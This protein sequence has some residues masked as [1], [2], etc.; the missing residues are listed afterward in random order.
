MRGDKDIQR[1]ALQVSIALAAGM[2][3]IVPVAYG[4]P[5]GE[6]VVKGGAEVT[7]TVAAS[8]V[9][10]AVDTKISSSTTNN[11]IDWHDFS[12]D[13]SE[14]VIF[15]NG[16]KT[17][18][19][20]NVVTGA[21]TS[22]INGV[23][24]GGNEVYIINPNGV[25]FG[26][27]ASVDVG[28]L[29]AS[30]RY[31]SDTVKNAITEDGSTMTNVLE[32]ASAG[33][34]TDIVNMG[35]INATNVVMEGQNIRFVNDTN[36][37]N[38]AVEGKKGVTSTSVTLKADTT[39][40]GYI[41]VG[42]NSGSEPGYTGDNIEYFKLLGT[43]W[44]TITNTI[45][46]DATGNYMLSENVNAG[47]SSASIT[48]EFSGKFDGNNHEISNISGASSLFSAT[49]GAEIYNVGIVDSTFSGSNTGMVVGNAQASNGNNTV[50]KN[51]Y[52]NSSISG[53][54]VSG[55]V[56]YGN[57][58]DIVQCYNIG[59]LPLNNS[60]AFI[61][62]VRSGTNKIEDSYSTANAHY[63]VSALIL[64]GATLNGNRLYSKGRAFW[65][66]KNG[67]ASLTN[68][69][70]E[71][72]TT[73]GVSTGNYYIFP[74]NEVTNHTTASGV[75]TKY[76]ATYT[77]S[78]P[79]TEMNWGSNISDTG[80]VVINKDTGVV[81]RPVWRIYEGQTMPLLTSQ[82]KGIKNTVYNFAYFDADDNK[83]DTLIY[84]GGSNGAKDIPAYTKLVNNQP[85]GLVYN[86]K[87][88]KMLGSDG[89]AATDSSGAFQTKGISAIDVS[90]VSYDTA[91]RKNATFTK[92]SQ[93]AG[94]QNKWAMLYSSQQGYDLYGNNIEIAPRHVSASTSDIGSVT[95]V[96]EY[97][98]NSTASSE[99]IDDFFS[100]DNTTVAGILSEDSE[101]TKVTF[102]GTAKFMKNGSA[103]KDVGVYTYDADLEYQDE[104]WASM[105]YVDL[106][107]TINLT[108]PTNNYLLTDTS[109]TGKAQG[110]ITQKSLTIGL[111]HENYSRVYN[112]HAVAKGAVDGNV[113]IDGN[114]QANSVVDAS[115]FKLTVKDTGFTA[116]QEG[117][118]GTFTFKDDNN[119][120]KTETVTYTFNDTAYYVE[121][122]GTTIAYA[123]DDNG[124][125]I[126]DDNDNKIE[127][128]DVGSYTNRVRFD[129]LKLSG[130]TVGNYK[131]VDSSGNV[132]YSASPLITVT[133][134]G[135]NKY[136][137]TQG[138][139]VTAGGALYASGTV[140]QRPIS[141]TGFSWYKPDDNQVLQK[142][143]AT[144]PYNGYSAYEAPVGY[145][146]SNAGV[147]SGDRGMLEGDNLTF[148]VQSAEFV[149]SD[150]GTLNNQNQRVAE[151]T[152]NVADAQGVLYT[153]SITGDS[154]RNYTLDGAAINTSGTNTVIGKGSL[155]ARTINLIV[156]AD[157]N[158]D[159]TYDGKVYV[160]GATED[161]PA[162]LKHADLTAGTGYLKYQNTD[163]D[164]HFLGDIDPDA[165]IKVIGTYQAMPAAEN[166][167]AV[168]AKDV[169]YNE[170]S[171]EV[172]DKN[173]VY[174]A[175]VMD[176]DDDSQ[177]YQFAII[178]NGN[179]NMT[180]LNTENTQ[181][182][183]SGTDAKGKIGQLEID[184]VVFSDTMSKTFDNDT[185]VKNIVN[186]GNDVLFKTN[187]RITVT[188]LKL[189]GSSALT[190]TGDTIDDVLNTTNGQITEGSTGDT[191]LIVGVYGKGSGDNWEADEHAGDKTIRYTLRDGI[192]QNHNYKLTTDA[193]VEG[194]GTINKLPIAASA[195]KL[196]RNDKPITK[197]Y[198]G[199]AD[200]ATVADS[201]GNVARTADY[202]LT[203]RKAYVSQDNKILPIA[204]TV[205]GAEYETR[206]HQNDAGE[207][208]LSVSYTLSFAQSE[209]Y[210]IEGL[211]NNQLTR[212]V[213]ANGDDITGTI[214]PRP[215]TVTTANI[216]NND[217][218]AGG[219]VKVYNALNTVEGYGYGE[220]LVSGINAQV[221]TADS[222]VTNNTEGTYNNKHVNS[223]DTANLDDDGLKPVTY[224]LSLA[225]NTY[226]DYKFVDD[227]GTEITSVIGK[228]T[229]TPLNINT[230]TTTAYPIKTYTGTADAENKLTTDNMIF[231]NAANKVVVVDRDHID[232]TKITGMYQ[233]TGNEENAADVNRGGSEVLDKNVLYSGVLAAL[234]DNAG[235]YI[236][237]DTFTGTGKIK[238]ATIS[239]NDFYLVISDNIT[240]TY[241][242]SEQVGEYGMTN[243][244]R[245]LFQRYWIDTNNSGVDT[246]QDGTVDVKLANGAFEYIIEKAEFTSADAGTNNKHVDYQIYVKPASINNY[247]YDEHDTVKKDNIHLPGSSDTATITTRDVVASVTHEQLSKYYDGTEAI[248]LGDNAAYSDDN[249]TGTLVQGAEAVTFSAKVGTVVQ[250]ADGSV[251]SKVQTG[252]VNSADTNISYGSYDGADVGIGTKTI[253]Y[254][255]QIGG[256]N[257]NNYRLVDADGNVLTNGQ[258]LSTM[259]NTINPFGV[260]V[261]TKDTLNKTYDG[262]KSVAK[263]DAEA[264]LVIGATPANGVA[265]EFVAITDTT[266]EYDDPNVYRLKDNSLT[267]DVTYSGLQFTSGNYTMVDANGNLLDYN[268]DSQSYAVTGKGTISPLKLDRDRIDVVIDVANK[269]YDNSYV[270]KKDGVETT[271]DNSYIDH[272][273]VK[274]ADNEWIDLGYEYNA[275]YTNKTIAAD[276]VTYTLGL[277]GKTNYNIEYDDGLFNEDYANGYIYLNG[278][279]YEWRQ[280]AAGTID[281][282]TVKVALTGEPG[283]NT[284]I[285]TYDGNESVT[286]PTN[287]ADKVQ[288]TGLDFNDGTSYSVSNIHYD[289][290]D[291]ARDG[292]GNVI[293]KNVFYSVALTGDAK[294]N[295]KIEA[296]DGTT[297]DAD[298]AINGEL[299]GKG[300]ITAKTLSIDFGYAEKPYD[301]TDDVEPGDIAPQLGGFAGNES[302][303]LDADAISLI[304][305]NYTNA[306]VNRTDE[307]GTVGFKGLTYEN[308]QAALTDYAGR[309]G[310][311]LNYTIA[312]TKSYTVDDAKGKIIPKE[313]D[314]V[315]AVWE[316]GVTR[317]YDTTK[318]IPDEASVLTLQVATP[319]D[320]QQNVTYSYAKAEYADPNVGNHALR[321][322]VD[323]VTTNLVNYEL[324]SEAA[325]NAKRWWVSTDTDNNFDGNEVKGTITARTLNLVDDGTIRKIYDGT[326][327]VEEADK[328]SLHFSALDEGYLAHDNVSYSVAATYRDK[329]ANVG[330]SDTPITVDY[331]LTLSGND[332]GNYKLS[333]ADANKLE[334]TTSGDIEKRKVYMEAKDI[335]GIDRK[336]RQKLDGTPDD[337]LPADFDKTAGHFALMDATADTGI[338]T[339]TMSNGETDD[340]DIDLSLDNVEGKYESPHVQRAAD[341][342]VIAQN[343]NF[344]GFALGGT[345][346]ATRLN[347]YVLVNDTATGSGTISPLPVTVAIK[348]A[349]TK[350]YDGETALSGTYAANSNLEVNGL[351]GK[352]SAN[353]LVNSARYGT[354]DAGGNK[355]YT[356]DITLGNRDYELTQ[357]NKMPA[358]AVANNGLSGTLAASDGTITPRLLTA[359]VITAMNKEYDGTTDGVENAQANISL[360][361]YIAKDKSNLGLTAVAVYDNA[362]AGKSEDSDELQKHTVTYTL[363]LSNKN[364]QLAD[365]TITGEGTI[366]RKGLTVVATPA[367]VNV[368]EAMP[369]FSGTVEGLIAKD[370]SLASLFTFAPYETTTS[371][372]P[373]TYEVY[374]WYSNRTAGNLGLNYTFAQDAGNDTAFTV[375]YVNT[376]NDNPDTKITPNSDIYN[377]ISKDM[378]SGFGDNGAAAIEY[379]DKQGNVVGTE[380]IGSG[381][382]H[383]AGSLNEMDAGVNSQDTKLAN[384]GIV[385]G[386]IV[387]IEGADAAGSADIAVSGDGTVI[388]LEVVPLQSEDAN[389][390]TGA[391]EITGMD[392]VTNTGNSMAEITGT[393]NMTNIGNSA[394]EIMGTD[395]M[396]NAS[397]QIDDRKL[398]NETED[399]AEAKE[400]EGEIAIES[401]DSKDDDEIELKIEKDGVNVA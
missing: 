246:D 143:D 381:E 165:Q 236:V 174:N 250:N 255:A 359:S 398:E 17:N 55:F 276:T 145:T 249:S 11:V 39:D 92:T 51:V 200:V 111:N 75:A 337:S 395:N 211:V 149:K 136:T 201:V 69:M 394:A 350:V 391:A 284:V 125:A 330:N 212:S 361:N 80:G 242:G 375:N 65:G 261:T 78:A 376:N 26:E 223:N 307:A 180:A 129:G 12:V 108:D 253:N 103:A 36:K 349:P 61:T 268:A 221:L 37:T 216:V 225:N 172:L 369:E 368:G 362:N 73:Q 367:A 104:D 141:S 259:E 188:D 248:Y 35:A 224:A 262:F 326:T 320:G 86:G 244:Q 23:I 209:D 287:A 298:T 237:A 186:N 142:Q 102:S 198:N 197:I 132:L 43:D 2:F 81:T 106:Q 325:A 117:T 107:G 302:F 299:T 334:G 148:T 38:A 168:G 32:T 365:E 33:M 105:S 295:Y 292:E 228:G 57:G 4:A 328:S 179:T 234:G 247:D 390:N 243:D 147:D 77:G 232:L 332:L 84:N 144:R 52:V 74:A 3:S 196:E 206:H 220:S 329:N 218:D 263:D 24:K 16:N 119:A 338:V 266:A 175:T 126:L 194:A 34:A 173:I 340:S 317:E 169:Y 239:H 47:N 323:G 22:E 341:G 370:S 217:K 31:V 177:N 227:G 59:S 115:D 123:K 9:T 140:S 293:A 40:G 99:A 20:M 150:T 251:A 138:A 82:F 267:H 345:A 274:L 282:A 163:A 63:G 229:I 89:N 222:N 397:A 181:A 25:I 156:N 230:I 159:K 226:G 289:G 291:V 146:V 313:V 127:R 354:A 151:A 301:A 18:N 304:T 113:T 279:N 311:A 303:D 153:V 21:N 130:N 162:Y 318:N 305:G 199:D 94:T 29:Y 58:V 364:Y 5:V 207:T 91:G 202:Y 392:D 110:A 333:D 385:G 176:G 97:D 87:T 372:N 256:G 42:Y 294:D 310:A 316:T 270:V 297:Y 322:N 257:S 254:T 154:A 387:N 215:I 296:A 139:A 309:N 90:L 64:S 167:P 278:D 245:D 360:S 178:N 137:I 182:E 203:D 384:I 393:D 193:V 399:K 363:N 70:M 272:F 204:V 396:T 374:G 71:V 324:T 389:T 240:Q 347:N 62:S 371:N 379:R 348:K 280:K 213:D 95:I 170:N 264:Q 373:G 285:K 131:L 185:E 275:E 183:F 351:L 260:K 358:I 158:M 135:N 210:D 76:V 195:V 56:G 344:T 335:S 327:A 219:V 401:S 54:N 67:T 205:E 49:K 53:S 164:T 308:L 121:A 114:V 44:S 27:T 306:N 14:Q 72:I 112:N 312:D 8:G 190:A 356:Y 100:G 235:N 378:N 377:Q 79:A 10:G 283:D 6:S 233:K 133:K 19:Y 101:T 315:K 187:D 157:A 15:D 66:N 85:D 265:A 269:T 30:T 28:S 386:D 83:V 343:I 346:D 48:N 1:L 122:D 68:A 116:N 383:G 118:G 171:K 288:L 88:L 152:K 300:T 134:D 353:L 124:N 314:D 321:Y 355:D 388:N 281:K 192:W 60:S 45:N 339:L 191:A 400:K 98:G 128:A 357:G 120:D 352:D 271:F 7:R 286:N 319:Y 161:N 277:G 273:K 241:S 290:A 46:N 208:N 109:F 366:S 160:S 252:L 189:N 231:G 336:Y 238:P 214:T 41:H 342:S 166:T 50:L 258:G 331:V 184:Q 382:I 96:K 13:K 155:T 93:S 380:A